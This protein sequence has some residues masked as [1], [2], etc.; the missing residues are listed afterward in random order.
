MCAVCIKECT[1]DI[2]DLFSS[3]CQNQ[4]WF[5]CYFC[6]NNGF[7]ILFIR[8]LKHRIYIF[9]IYYDSHTLL[10]FWNSKLCSIQTCIFLWNLVQIYNQTRCKF[11]DRYG[12]TAGTKVITFLYDRSNFFSSEQ[13]LDLSLCWRITLL[14][15]CT[16]GL[17][18]LA[19]MCL[20]WSGCSTT[21]VTTGTSAEKDDLISRIRIQTFY[22][23]SWSCTHNCSDL[24]SLCYII[25]MIYF[26]YKSCCKT[27][28]VTIWAVTCC[29]GRN[30]L[31]LWKLS[32]KSIL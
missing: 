14:Y 20:G 30:D 19:V 15:F 2:Y 10:R 28:L 9:W 22:R 16:T 25:R 21:T 11:S 8:I 26:I 12:Y 7:Q 17:K 6:Y 24:H 4:S 18:R 23:T 3:P 5:F 27:D 29:C 1:G 31:S 13:S 32:R